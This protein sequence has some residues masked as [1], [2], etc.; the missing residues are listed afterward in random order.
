MNSHSEVRNLALTHAMARSQ[1]PSNVNPKSKPKPGSYPQKK[2]SNAAGYAKRKSLKS[3][4]L[5]SG[6]SSSLGD[7]YEY[8]GER[9]R[10]GKLKLQLEKDEILGAGR[11][12]DSDDDMGEGG[13]GRGGMHPRLLNEREGDE[14]EGL[15][16]DE[17]EEIDSD[18][19][20]EESDEERFAGFSFASAGAVSLAFSL[21]SIPSARLRPT[22]SFVYHDSHVNL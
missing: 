21:P 5:S 11:P 19:A 2:N 1:R 6:P 22:M 3:K 4:T 9:V 16:E 13:S 18:E 8:S 14:E 20:F 7:V 15:G 10:R 12:A 17:D